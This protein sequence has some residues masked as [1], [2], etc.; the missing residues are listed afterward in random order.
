[1]RLKV[2]LNCFALFV[3][4]AVK[5][6]PLAAH[7]EVGLVHAPGIADRPLTGLPAF[8]ELWEVMYDPAQDC[9]GGDAD[10]EPPGQLGQIP[11]TKLKAQIP[12]Y[13]GD[14]NVVGEPTLTKE[15]MTR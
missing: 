15:W 9:A 12:A 11:I 4:G 1:M 13:T 8:L 3:D 7:L 2:G 6:K 5:V 14:D 10:T